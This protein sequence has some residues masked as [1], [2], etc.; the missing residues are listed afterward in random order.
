MKRE[1]NFN[2]I[3]VS[4]LQKNSRQFSISIAKFQDNVD[5]TTAQTIAAETIPT[6]SKF[7]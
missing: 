6:P 7:F 2:K 3:R 1:L 4:V 5:L